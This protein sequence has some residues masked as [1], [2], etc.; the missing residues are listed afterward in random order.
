LAKDEFFVT[1]MNAKIHFRRD[2]AGQVSGIVVAQKSH[3][4]AGTKCDK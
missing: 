3:N 2:E 1:S 4:L